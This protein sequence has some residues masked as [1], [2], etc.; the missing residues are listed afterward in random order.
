MAVALALATALIVVAVIRPFSRLRPLMV[1]VSVDL[2][3]VAVLSP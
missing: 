1:E 2:A 3:V